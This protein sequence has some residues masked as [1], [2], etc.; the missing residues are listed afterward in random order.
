MENKQFFV[1]NDNLTITDIVE[2]SKN[3]AVFN[4]NEIMYLGVDRN[5]PEY[6]QAGDV[7]LYDGT[8]FILSH[9]GGTGSTGPAGVGTQ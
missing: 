4:A 6:A 2:Y 7:L 8:Q 3:H 5:I 1:S 9:A